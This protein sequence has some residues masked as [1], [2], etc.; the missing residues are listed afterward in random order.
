MKT[1]QKKSLPFSFREKKNN[2]NGI[3]KKK[4][5]AGDELVVIKDVSNGKHYYLSVVDTFVYSKREYVVM[6][7]YDPDDGNH[8]KPELVIMRTEF[9]PKG[10]QL[11]YSI[12]DSDELE[13]AFSCF[14]RRYYNSS[15]P[16]K[17]D[18]V[19]VR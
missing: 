4:S 13:V 5:G 18:R 7:N 15:A 14:M 11:F 16:G 17:Q 3:T 6:Y 10:D 8:E 2:G 1:N 9:T 12:K 19:G